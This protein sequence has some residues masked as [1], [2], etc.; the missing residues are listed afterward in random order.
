MNGSVVCVPD[1]VPVV[2]VVRAIDTC[3]LV[4]AKLIPPTPLTIKSNSSPAVALPVTP[5][6]FVTV[7]LAE[8][9]VA[10]P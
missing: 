3:R 8:T 2:V 9:I 5:V 1:P 7:V 4:E 6:M 10:G